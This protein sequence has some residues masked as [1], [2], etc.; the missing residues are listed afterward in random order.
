MPLAELFPRSAL[1]GTTGSRAREEYL[2]WDRKVDIIVERSDLVQS[3]LLQAKYGA[4]D[5][6]KESAFN[7]HQRTNPGNRFAFDL[8]E[9]TEKELERAIREAE[10]DLAQYQR[11]RETLALR[12]RCARTIQRS[13]R[14]YLLRQHSK[15]RRLRKRM[16]DLKLVEQEAVELIQR[17]YRAFKQKS[18]TTSSRCEGEE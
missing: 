7:A 14:N 10:E 5:R 11:S 3:S 1:G 9:S 8:L 13:F 6:N 16:N 2:A 4:E 18:K 17:R 12:Q 15:L